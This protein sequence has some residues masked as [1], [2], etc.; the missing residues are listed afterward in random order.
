M[1]VRD[2]FVNI[3]LSVLV[4]VVQ[5]CDLVSAQNVNL[6]VYDFEP[7]GLV[8]ACG[9]ASPLQT[10][11]RLTHSAADPYFAVNGADGD[12]AIGEEIVSANEEERLPR[13]LVRKREGIDGVGLAFPKYALS[14]DSLTPL[15]CT[16]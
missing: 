3:G 6:S 9:E 4:P 8:K 15:G 2:T 16:L 1:S 10:L 14:D 5:L 12:A 13:I 11:E 7:Q